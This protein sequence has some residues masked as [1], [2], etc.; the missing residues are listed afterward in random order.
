MQVLI[1]SGSGVVGTGVAKGRANAEG[2]SWDCCLHLF[3]SSRTEA[4]KLFKGFLMKEYF[5]FRRCK[6]VASIYDALW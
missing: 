6:I 4:E 1:T 2:V 3:A 5:L